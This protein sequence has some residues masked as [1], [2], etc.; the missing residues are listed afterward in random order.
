MD[1]FMSSIFGASWRTGITGYA[2][3]AL[4]YVMSYFHDGGVLPN[5]G[6]GWVLFAGAILRALFAFNTKDK[7]VTNS[8]MG[9]TVEAHEISKG[10]ESV[11]PGPAK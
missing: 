1:K 2:E 11:S 7:Q 4:L 6:Q 5:T 10:L 8:G 9:T 3:A